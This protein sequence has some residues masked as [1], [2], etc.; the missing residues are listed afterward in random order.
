M[1]VGQFVR[2]ATAITAFVVLFIGNV[3]QTRLSASESSQF[4]D[5]GVFRFRY[6]QG[7]QILE[8]SS[9]RAPGVIVHPADSKLQHFYIAIKDLGFT[10]EC[11]AQHERELKF[12]LSEDA[13]WTRI[14]GPFKETWPAG[15]ACSS[16]LV[17]QRTTEAQ[18]VT[19]FVSN[20]RLALVMYQAAGGALQPEIRQLVLGSFGFIGQQSSSASND[21]G[22]LSG[23]DLR[24]LIGQWRNGPALFT[25]YADAKFTF[26]VTA[27]SYNS[28]IIPRQHGTYRLQ[29]GR[30]LMNWQTREDLCSFR[31][32]G[33][34][35][36]MR[37]RNN[38]N[39]EVIWQKVE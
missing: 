11:G 6:P 28:V 27:T 18:V 10:P 5:G 25:F 36:A 1:L 34:S 7:W 31:I 33:G 35:M 15:E 23:S 26:E 3:L 16:I 9:Q 17:N 12:F 13:T 30:L 19:H 29:S 2:N 4:F 20:G 32:N 37:C 14:R 38:N 21:Q 22:D 24:Q 39:R 8:R